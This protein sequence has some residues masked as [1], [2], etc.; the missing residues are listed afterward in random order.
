QTFQDVNL[1]SSQRQ[2]V[3][4]TIGSLLEVTQQTIQ[5]IMQIST[6]TPQGS[7]PLLE[8]SNKYFKI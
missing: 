7:I 6:R 2:T 8:V 5:N 3:Q 4:D 1:Y